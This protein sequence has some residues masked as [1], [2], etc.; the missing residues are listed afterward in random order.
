MPSVLSSVVLLLLATS[1]VAASDICAYASR[2][3][4]ESYGCCQNILPGTCCSWPNNYGWSV[5]YQNMPA[6]W[7][8]RTFSDSNCQRQWLGISPLVVGPISYRTTKTLP[9]GC[10]RTGVRV[11]GSPPRRDTE[12][13][14]DVLNCVRP[15]VIGFTTKDGKEHLVKVPEGTLDELNEWVKTEIFA[16]LLEFESVSGDA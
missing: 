12:D 15:N 13:H 6:S 5:R 7:S 3:C 2:N 4:V 1:L 14:N 8:G 11:G 16:K 9:I 10:L